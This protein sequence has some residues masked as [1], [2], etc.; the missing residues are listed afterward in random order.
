M[1]NS[2]LDP[3]WVSL[4][5]GPKGLTKSEPQDMVDTILQSRLRR[6]RVAQQSSMTV[7]EFVEKKFVPEYVA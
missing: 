4:A 6:R 5:T 1:E 7:S 2:K 3:V